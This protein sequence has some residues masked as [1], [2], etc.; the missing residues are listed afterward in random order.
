LIRPHPELGLVAMNGPNDPKPGLDV[1]DGR[2]VF[3]DGR[4]ESDFDAI[5]YFVARH[6][7]DLDEGDGE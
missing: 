7:I 6:G 1:R 2:V 5:D 3:L 4:P